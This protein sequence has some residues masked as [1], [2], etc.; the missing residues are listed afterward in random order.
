MAANWKLRL[1]VGGRAPNSIRA[2][3]NLK[4]ICENHLKD[5]YTIDVIDLLENPKQAKEDQILAVPTLVRKHPLPERHIPGDL[6]NTKT[7]LKTL[8][9][10]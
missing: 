1:Y 5:R 7:V 9:L 10:A 8:D 3:E 4:R 2:L 6:S